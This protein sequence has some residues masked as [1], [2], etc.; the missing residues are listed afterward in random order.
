MP[1]KKTRAVRAPRR[2]REPEEARREILE[3]A[4]RV[5]SKKG[6]DAVG[7]KEV[8]REAG[9]SHG[10]VTHYF[11]TYKSLVSAVLLR[12]IQK[13]REE[14]LRVVLSPDFTPDATS[15]L[16]LLFGMVRDPGH[17]RIVMW[18]LLSHESS[19]DILPFEEQG[20]VPLIDALT[21]RRQQLFKHETKEEA[22]R[23]E[24]QLFLIALAAAYGFAVGKGA[25]LKSLG[26]KVTPDEEAQFE[27]TLVGLFNAHL[28]QKGG[29]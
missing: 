13:A 15:L 10:L 18:A 1:S 26:R 17:A 24:E 11:G 14:A 22:R 5:I 23:Q 25:F 4:E 28:R 19:A 29:E 21:E 20:V 8:A 9:V 3:A 27:R 16:H 2:R 7:L 6:P 12:R